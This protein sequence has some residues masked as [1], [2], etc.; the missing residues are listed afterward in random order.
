M[1]LKTLGRKIADGDRL[2][3]A[4]F[5]DDAT[6]LLTLILKELRKLNLQLSLITDEEIDHA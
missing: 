6:I 1:S 4:V 5:D 3:E 2:E